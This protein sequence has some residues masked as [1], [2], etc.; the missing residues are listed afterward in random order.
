M[1]YRAHS[2]LLICLLPLLAPSCRSS[3]ALPPAAH[4]DGD[5]RPIAELPVGVSAPEGQLTL[6]ADYASARD[7]RVTVYLI[8]RTGRTIDL[9]N[10]DGDPYLK[11][12]A[13]TG[14]AGPWERAQ[15]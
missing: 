7:Q 5:A 3:P 14:S 13:Q 15:R 4:V 6:H 10:Q 9:P 1:S 2:L 12:E 11:L 8:N